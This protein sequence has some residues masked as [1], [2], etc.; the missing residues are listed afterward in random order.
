M[1]MQPQTLGPCSLNELMI[2]LC[3]NGRSLLLLTNSRIRKEC[4]SHLKAIF[5]IL[6]ASL[7]QVLHSPR[8]GRVC[9]VRKQKNISLAWYL[10]ISALFN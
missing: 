10:H 2:N 3:E 5:S 8:L 7:D 1:I 9:F 6:C 4:I